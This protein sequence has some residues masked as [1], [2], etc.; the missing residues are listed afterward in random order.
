MGV[1]LRL[2]LL[3]SGLYKCHGIPGSSSP[4]ASQFLESA[5]IEWCPTMP[6]SPFRMSPLMNA[7][8]IQSAHEVISCFDG[9]LGD[10]LS[11]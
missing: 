1:L 3:Q 7:V 9:D 11:M 8:A 5:L 2:L 4:D 10:S 6:V